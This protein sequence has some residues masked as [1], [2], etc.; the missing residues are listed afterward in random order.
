MGG[1]CVRSREEGRTLKPLSF[2]DF[3]GGSFFLFLAWTE[4]GKV[5][6]GSLPRL[7]DIQGSCGSYWEVRCR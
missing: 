7:L 2:F 1:G 3:A 5:L 6:E 4:L